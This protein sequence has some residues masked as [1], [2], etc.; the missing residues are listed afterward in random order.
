MSEKRAI[1]ALKKRIELLEKALEDKDRTHEH[2]K[3][4]M[5]NIPISLSL[6]DNNGRFLLVNPEVERVLET[7]AEELY[8]KTLPEIFPDEGTKNLEIIRKVIKGKK[9]ISGEHRY[10]IH[11]KP[12]YFEINRLPV[13]DDQGNVSSVMS[14]ST[15]IT[16]KR[17]AD[18]LLRVQQ[19]I[20]SIQSLSESFKEN[21]EILFNH[22][23]EI[24]W[25][26]A[27]GI[28]LF[29]EDKKVL[30][31][32]YHRELSENFVNATKVYP[33]HSPP[34]KTVFGKI[35]L[36]LTK[37]EFIPDILDLLINEKLEFLC[38][39]PLVYKNKVLGSLNLA[40]RSRNDLN[41]FERL[42]IQSIAARV[43]GLIQLV[44]TQENL[45]KSN[46]S[47]SKALKDLQN[48]RNKLIQ[49]SRLESLGELSA[50]LAHEVNQPLS[51]ISLSLQN[52]EE[53]IK[54]G[55]ADTI[56]L[57]SKFGSLFRNVEKIKELIDHV[58]TFS[59]QQKDNLFERININEAV[60]RALSL[61]TEQLR[62]HHITVRKELEEKAGNYVIGNMSR[63]EQVFLNL[64]ANARYALDKKEKIFYEKGFSKEIL[65]SASYKRKFVEILFRD[66][67]TGISEK[68]LQLIFDP[69]FTTK[70]EGEGTGLGLSIVYG[71][72]TE[73][74]GEISVESE[75]GEYTS[76]KVRIPFIKELDKKI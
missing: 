55:K 28:Y 39:L 45:R 36:F 27:G 6:T 23:F 1:A 65:I 9:A 33:F 38:V 25:I 37:N 42:T 26:D 40:S 74:Q 20:D 19:K 35:P 8:G 11:G 31:L 13:F 30:E 58:R 60:D 48:N 50:G 10:V 32:V 16:E 73:M 61:I 7:P 52:L 51:V 44:N 21:L 76:I 68:D 2:Y 3:T 5:D 69:F 70:P 75:E 49:K 29:D 59:R 62:S 12:R 64:L 71:I 4:I 24:D 22:L 41:E 15:E 17:I 46:E 56:Y 54:N 57:D 43:A 34:A 53:R 66:N 67:G 18:K 72:I 14:I 47:L 63:L